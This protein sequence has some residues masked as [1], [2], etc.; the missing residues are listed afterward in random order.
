MHHVCAAAAVASQDGET[1]PAPRAAAAQ[2]SARSGEQSASHSAPAARGGARAGSTR[3]RGVGE[4]SGLRGRAPRAGRRR[5]RA[6]THPGR[7][8][9]RGGPPGARSP[10]RRGALLEGGPAGRTGADRWS[11]RRRWA[12]L[13]GA[14]GAP[15]AAACS[16]APTLQAGGPRPRTRGLAL[17]RARPSAWGASGRNR[18]SAGRG[19]CSV[20]PQG[21]WGSGEAGARVLVRRPRRGQ[22]AAHCPL[23]LCKQGYLMIHE[24]SSRPWNAQGRATR[25][26]SKPR[27]AR[28]GS[29]LVPVLLGQRV[30]YHTENAPCF[31]L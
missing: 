14:R 11:A 26:D 23:T 31:L 9:A 5:A 27:K 15:G 16:P 20:L 2:G 29:R 7:A 6:R 13:L 22:R 21:S 10:N 8:R 17:C 1:T 12:A 19:G 18:G 30:P 4:E 25:G 28:N 24:S 3:P